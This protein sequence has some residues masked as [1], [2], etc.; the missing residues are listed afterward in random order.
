[1]QASLVSCG[2]QGLLSIVSFNHFFRF[3]LSL[4]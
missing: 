4:L 1:V 3:N 2:S